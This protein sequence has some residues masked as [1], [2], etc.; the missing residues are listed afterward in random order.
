[1]CGGGGAQGDVSFPGYI[2]AWMKELL[3]DGD[4]SVSFVNELDGLIS[5]SEDYTLGRDPY[6]TMQFDHV[7]RQNTEL[8][9]GGLDDLGRWWNYNLSDEFDGKSI[10]SAVDDSLT[11]GQVETSGIEDLLHN[12]VVSLPN[13]RGETSST[14]DEGFAEGDS[15][16]DVVPETDWKEALAKAADGAD[17]DLKNIDFSAIASAARTGAVDQIAK[18]IDNA[19]PGI[20]HKSIGK[21]IIDKAISTADQAEALNDLN[22]QAVFNK[23]KAKAGEVVTAAVSKAST[24]ANSQPVDDVIENFRRRI[25]GEYE[26]RVGEF[27]ASMADINAM[28]SSAYAVG[29]ALIRSEHEQRVSEFGSELSLSVYQQGLEIYRQS[30][31]ANLQSKLGAEEINKNSRERLIN[32]TAEVVA[33]VYSQARQLESV[34][35]R[36]QQNAYG[37]SMET[38]AQVEGQNK[39][40]RDQLIQAGAEAIVQLIQFKEQFRQGVA[41][42]FGQQFNSLIR[43][44]LAEDELKLQKSTAS[45]ELAHQ[46]VQKAWDR[47]IQGRLS[48]TSNL[49]SIYSTLQETENAYKSSEMN[50]RAR[51]TK[52]ELDRWEQGANIL[53]APSGMARQL[54]EGQ[55][56]AGGAIGGA[57]TGAGTGAGVG[58]AVPGIGTAI[59]AAAGAVVGGVAGY[60]GA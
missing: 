28:N 20:D 57:L 46:M 16:S 38:K 8:G 59:G 60:L 49:A 7:F 14:L 37:A 32:T 33:G 24:V 2:D 4:G 12:I 54:P 56:K 58:S 18:V 39:Q 34:F 47:E 51:S 31:Q 35:A 29:L 13:L 45:S 23:A 50:R 52:W 43:S 11:K 5:Q 26:D 1:M 40:S 55:S 22:W 30:L 17:A 19:S 44:E 10:G 42:L 15:K 48:A 25:E 27:A 21:G 53:A 36:L 3:T 9:T 6:E 41:E